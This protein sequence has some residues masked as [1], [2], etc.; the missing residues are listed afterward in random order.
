MVGAEEEQTVEIHGLKSVTSSFHE[1]KVIEKE[2]ANQHPNYSFWLVLMC[3]GHVYVR[4]SSILVSGANR[5][6]VSTAIHLLGRHITFG[7]V[8]VQFLTWHTLTSVSLFQY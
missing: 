5:Q 7:Q 2:H 1:C 8:N 4:H 3:I 6:F